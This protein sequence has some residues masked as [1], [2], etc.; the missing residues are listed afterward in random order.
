MTCRPTEV[1][2]TFLCM[3]LWWEWP[4]A[5]A[6]VCRSKLGTL[7]VDPASLGDDTTLTIEGAEIRVRTKGRMQQDEVTKRRRSGNAVSAKDERVKRGNGRHLEAKLLVNVFSFLSSEDLAE[8]M[9]V[10]KHWERSAREGSDSL[11]RHVRVAQKWEMGGGGGEGHNF[12]CKV[13]AA[14]EELEFKYTFERD[15]EHMESLGG[16]L[17]SNLQFLEIPHNSVPL[18]FFPI[19]LSRCSLLKILL[20]DG[21]PKGRDPIDI[22]HPQLETLMLRCWNPRVLTID[23]PNLTHLSTGGTVSNQ[24]LVERWVTQPFPSF[25][26]PRLTNLLLAPN[27]CTVAVWQFLATHA[28]NIKWLQVVA[29]KEIP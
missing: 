3:V 19:L 12:M 14:A 10:S 9:L 18:A 21:E 24:A 4:M 25:N 13:V 20:M 2:R 22:R 6:Q 26:C 27:H 11:W 23:C 7:P 1:R 29:L 28:P 15:N 17:G 16:L 5:C 8:V